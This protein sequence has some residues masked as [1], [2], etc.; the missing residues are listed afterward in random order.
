MTLSA[1]INLG[2]T[3]ALLLLAVVSLTS[4][5]TMRVLRVA[6]QEVS[7]SQELRLNLE[8]VLA[9]LKD[10]QGGVGG[11]ALT[12]QPVYL[13]SYVQAKSELAES[14]RLL[15][16]DLSAHPTLKLGF[17]ELAAM[18]DEHLDEA[19]ALLAARVNHGLTGAAGKV[20]EGGGKRVM[21]RIRVEINGRLLEESRLLKGRRL[22]EERAYRISLGVIL[23][24]S[25]LAL[26]IVGGAAFLANL[27]IA[28]K[29]RTSR[30]IEELNQELRRRA[31]KLAVA[32][33]ELETFTYSVSHDL[34][35]P[36]RAI[37]GFSGML[38]GKHAD[39]L[40]PEGQRLL[41]VV[42]TNAR[43]MG[44]LIDDLLSFSKVSRKNL[45]TQTVKMR[46]MVVACIADLNIT[47]RSPIV[48]EDMPDAVGDIALLRQVVLNL[49][50]NAVKF[51]K[52]SQ[53]P[54]ITVGVIQHEGKTAYFV[55]D[56][57]VGFDMKYV[58]KLFGVFQRLHRLEDFEGTGVGLAIVHRVIERHGGKVW[59]TSQQEVGTTF[60]FSLSSETQH[61]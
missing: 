12:G 11:Y 56:N 58:G 14:L 49:L 18:C 17:D 37:E 59:A 34:R 53:P 27:D 44:Q 55:R 60:F 23:G 50:S 10:V 47:E 33:R 61:D 52:H 21:D 28:A 8:R 24:G 4:F 41:G 19:E 15:Q 36:L 40:S 20:A 29:A 13:T 5:R 25:I 31:E 42:R 39:A 51:S 7:K 9:S 22:H 57:G 32:N 2:F 26:L 54:R 38:S 45:L 16:N 48:V 35:A 6:D 3:A 46:D 43:R 30:Q 1:K